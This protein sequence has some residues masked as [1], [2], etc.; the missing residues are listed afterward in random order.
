M[1]FLGNLIKR[2]LH[3][4]ESLDLDDAAVRFHG[5]AGKTILVF[6]SE[7]MKNVAIVAVCAGAVLDLENIGDDVN[8]N[9]C[10]FGMLT[11]ELTPSDRPPRRI[12]G[13][14]SPSFAESSTETCRV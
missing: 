7:Y 12:V 8:G 13:A 9:R 10:M 6:V 4:L 1:E 3:L 5:K 2:R 14:S 11:A